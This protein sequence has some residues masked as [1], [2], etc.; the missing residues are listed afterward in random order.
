VHTHTL[1]RFEVLHVEAPVAGAAGN[2][3]RT[4]AHAFSAHE[5]Q[6]KCSLV[7][8]RRAFDAQHLLWDRH[9]DAEFLRLV[10]GPGHQSHAGDAGRKTE[11]VLDAR[12]SAGLAAEGAAIKRQNGEALGCG[13][14][15]GRQASGSGSND[16]DVVD[17]ASVDWSDET[18]TA[19]EVVLSWIAQKLSPGAQHDR[20]LARIEVES[21][22]ESARIGV[23]I[24]VEQLVRMSVAPEEVLESENVALM[25]VADDHR[26][27]GALFDQADAPENQGAHDPLTELGLG[28][29][30]RSQPFRRNDQTLNRSLGVRIYQRRTTRELGQLAHER[31]GAVRDNV[32][33]AAEMIVG[34][35]RPAEDV[36]P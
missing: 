2:H 32:L 23:G 15:R 21:I 3:H 13:I 19:S 9:L 16:R 17:G 20:Q 30:Q 29:Q 5:L 1:E 7:G 22:E 27:T 4:S 6:P 18:D 31:A 33:A 11:V 14:D 28:D 10:V 8:T 12:R 36:N 26:A 24:G 25:G 34:D 35:R